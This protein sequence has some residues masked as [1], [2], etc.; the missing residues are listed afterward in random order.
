MRIDGFTDVD[1]FKLKVD[2]Y[3]KV[4]YKTKPAPGT[5]GPILPGNS[6]I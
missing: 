1:E 5:T 2:E 3:R 4:F 6:F